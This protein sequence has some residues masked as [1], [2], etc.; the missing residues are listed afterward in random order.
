MSDTAKAYGVGW[1]PKRIDLFG[2]VE[3]KPES[4]QHVITFPGGAI[5]LS[6]TSNNEY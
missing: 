1:A 2:D 6:R 4:A 5:E 3:K